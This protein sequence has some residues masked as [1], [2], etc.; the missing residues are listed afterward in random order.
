MA[1][2]IF[3]RFPNK[4]R[5]AL[6]IKSALA[7][8]RATCTSFGRVSRTRDHLNP[9]IV[10]LASPRPFGFSALSFVGHPPTRG[11]GKF[12]A[13]ADVPANT[14]SLALSI[15][16]ICI[17][18]GIGMRGS[19]RDVELRSSSSL[20][21]SL[22]ASACRRDERKGEPSSAGAEVERGRVENCN[23]EG[24]PREV[25]TYVRSPLRPLRCTVY[26]VAFVRRHRISKFNVCSA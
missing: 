20:V 19:G 5:R 18:P 1:S 3:A 16:G 11:D 9:M 12:Y 10:S 15:F 7:T 25:H 23:R 22:L 2:T 8:A 13:T 26:G 4:R 6:G 14:R 21:A 24:V 17:F